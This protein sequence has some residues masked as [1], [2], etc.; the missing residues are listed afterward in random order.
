MMLSSQ[1]YDLRSTNA[2]QTRLLDIKVTENN[3]ARDSG[4]PL[5]EVGTSKELHR[6]LMLCHV[7]GILSPFYLSCRHYKFPSNALSALSWSWSPSSSSCSCSTQ[8]V[9]EGSR[10]KKARL[11][12]ATSY[13]STLQS[14][15]LIR[16]L[17]LAFSSQRCCRE[18]C[19]QIILPAWWDLCDN[20]SLA[21]R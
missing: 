11:Y 14:P 9:G 3:N 15:S 20:R 21:D 17:S 19:S 7:L 16:C 4:D 10:R 5:I 8:Y 6:L 18:S 12:L 1:T 13:P 2:L